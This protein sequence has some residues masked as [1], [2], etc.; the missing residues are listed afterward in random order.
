MQPFAVRAGRPVLALALALG[1]GCASEPRPV[2]SDAGSVTPDGLHRVRSH[3]VPLA[4]V[5]PGTDFSHYTGL[6]ID[7][8]TVSY[9]T[10]EEDFDTDR[11]KGIFQEALARQLGR[12]RVFS[13]VSEA[14]PGVL[15]VSA[16]I[17]DLTVEIPPDRGGE[18][19]FIVSAGEM[20]LVLD[21]RDSRTGAPVAR[22]ADR[23]TIAP[24]SADLV[25]GFQSSPVNN[26]GALREIF[27]GWARILRSGLEDLRRIRVEP[28]PSELTASEPDAELERVRERNKELMLRIERERIER[29]REQRRKRLE[30]EVV[31]PGAE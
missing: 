4:F 28:T 6:L 9:T 8:V 13:V 11:L 1:V 14:G 20:T 10:P 2:E 7:P 27:N 18:L 26:W 31:E 22:M 15:R 24:S 19:Y 16:H 23:R 25:G 29:L 30:L 17:V 5:R 12:S 3:R 21:V